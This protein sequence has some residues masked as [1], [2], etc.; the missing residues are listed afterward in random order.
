MMWETMRA[1]LVSLQMRRPQA[2]SR[3]ICR[4]N[5]YLEKKEKKFRENKETAQTEIEESV[6]GGKTESKGVRRLMLAL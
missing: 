4:A 3:L 1:A 5:R 2:R 6:G